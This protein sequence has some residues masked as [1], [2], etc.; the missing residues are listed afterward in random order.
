MKTKLL[1]M[2]NPSVSAIVDAELYEELRKLKW[3]FYRA[4]SRASFYVVRTPPGFKPYHSL[5][6]YVVELSYS[7]KL[8]RV[9]LVVF[10]DGDSLNCTIDNLDQITQSQHKRS[11]LADKQDHEDIA[12]V[13]G[14]WV[15][16][17]DGERVGEFKTKLEAENAFDKKLVVELG[18]LNAVERMIR[19]QNYKRWLEYWKNKEMVESALQREKV[20]VAPVDPAIKERELIEWA[21]R[22]ARQTL[23]VAG[24]KTTTTSIPLRMPG[25][26]K[27]SFHDALLLPEG[28]AFIYEING[29]GLP[30]KITVKAVYMLDMDEEAR[31]KSL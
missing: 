21:I 4:T 13:N 24:I 9:E 26:K 8:T 30:R 6:R 2:V 7:V 22:E 17:F 15:G 5:H 25:S 3:G 16:Y 20:A 31:T 11:Q 1:V 28:K 12:L 10:K 29:D 18:R 27:V 14:K 19:P 23:S